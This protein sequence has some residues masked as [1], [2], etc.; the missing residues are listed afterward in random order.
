MFEDFVACVNTCVTAE[1][2][3]GPFSCNMPESSKPRVL[4]L[5]GFGESSLLLG[6]ST[7]GLSKALAS[8][9]VELDTSLDGFTK[10]KTN[11]E[12]EAIVDEEYKQMCMKG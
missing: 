8:K 4:F 9:G 12:F 5:H 3:G 10:L 7:A 2:P 1:L 11:E 6:A